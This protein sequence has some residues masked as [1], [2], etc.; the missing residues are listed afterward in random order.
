LII[1]SVKYFISLCVLSALCGSIAF[2]GE[3]AGQAGSFLRIG[4]GPRAKALGDAYTAVADN[5]YAPYY[6]PAGLAFLRS[7]EAA[8]SYGLLSFDRTFTYAGFARPLPPQAG[9]GFGILQSGFKDSEAR[10]SDGETTGEKIEDSQYTFFM[11]FGIRFTE[12]VSAGITP[13]LI[14]SKIYDV[15]ASSVGVDLGMMYKPL[16][17]LTLGVSLHE[18]GQSLEYSRDASGFGNEKTKDK[19]PRVTKLG[20]AYIFPL[21]GSI[22]NLFFVSDLEMNSKQSSKWHFGVEANWLD[23]YYVRTGLD[24]LDW[25]AGISI[26]FIVKN[27]KFKFDYAYVLDRRSSV[28]YGT[29]DFG[30]AY[31]F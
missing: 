13:K 21:N 16:P 15:S 27:K 24:D 2:A 5:A 3:S 7:R 23:K 25:T 11:G 14:Y 18:L 29:S 28:G 26:P 6:N 30:L 17:R 9:F 20:A 1:K 4:L 19:L 22:K 12:K 10:L 8:L 31:V